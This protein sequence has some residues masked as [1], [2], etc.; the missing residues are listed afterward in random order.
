MVAKLDLADKI[1]IRFSVASG[2]AGDSKSSFELE[3]NIRQ[4]LHQRASTNF[5]PA[6]ICLGCCLTDFRRESEAVDP[7]DKLYSKSWEWSLRWRQSRIEC[8]ELEILLLPVCKSTN[9]IEEG[10]SVRSMMCSITGGK[11]DGSHMEGA[12]GG[13]AGKMAG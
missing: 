1:K 11:S 6:A 9:T 3:I 2:G 4:L 13:T 7:P 10:T 12:T 8:Q 5:H